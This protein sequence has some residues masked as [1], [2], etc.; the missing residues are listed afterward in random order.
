M[1]GARCWQRFDLPGADVRL[2]RFCDAAQAHEWFLR[3]HAEIPWEQHRLR[4]FGREVDSPR[5]SCWVGDAGTAYTYSRVLFEPRPWTPA[6][7]PA[8]PCGV[9]S[10]CGTLHAACS[11]PIARKYP[12]RCKHPWL[13]M[14]SLESRVR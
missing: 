8:G 3:L 2:A 11:S 5:L 13:K 7:L 9:R 12:P 14:R 1:S 10:G 4:L 6:R